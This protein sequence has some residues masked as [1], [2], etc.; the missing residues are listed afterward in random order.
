MQ[1]TLVEKNERT[2]D[3]IIC[4]P[5]MQPARMSRNGNFVTI[6]AFDYWKDTKKATLKLK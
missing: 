1:F 5:G 3:A 4:D 6:H 2:F